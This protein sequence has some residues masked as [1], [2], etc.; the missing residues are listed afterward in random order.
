MEKINI[1]ELIEKN[2]ITKLNDDYNM[3]LLNKIRETFTDFEQQL[4]VSSFYCY[5]NYNS[6]TDFVIDLDDVWKFM[7]FNQKYNALRVLEKNFKVE[8][9]YKQLYPQGK[10]NLIIKPE[11]QNNI[12]KLF[13]QP[14]EIKKGSGGYNIK[15]IFLTVKCFKSMCLK[16]GTKKAD[17]IHEY[18]MKL[19]EILHE[20][21]DEQCTEL[22]NQLNNQI[23]INE[24]II[25]EHEVKIAE[26]EQ[27]IADKEN[28]K[29]K[30]IEE[31]ELLNLNN[32]FPYIYIF[33]KDT[34]R[35]IP[36]L[37]I[38][39]S[40]NVY[41]R[42]K[43]FKCTNP[44]SKL[45]YYIKIDNKPILIVENFIHNLLQKYN[46]GGEVFELPVEKAIIIIKSIVTFMNIV[47]EDENND[48]LHRLHDSIQ[49]I[50]SNIPDP[51][52]FTN[53]IST[54]T[55]FIPE[56]PLS[57][58]IIQNDEL[59]L[60]FNQYIDECCIVRDD[61]EV[62]SSEIIGQYRIWSKTAGEE[63]FHSFKEYLDTRFRPKR[64]SHQIKDQI[65]HGYSGVKLKEILYKRLLV[66]SN[67]QEFIFNCCVFKPDGKVLYSELLKEYNRWKKSIHKP[68]LETD[69]KTLK[70]YLKNCEY[71]LYRNVW[72]SQG[73]GNGFYGII[74]KNN[75]NE[76]F[77]KGTSSTG[78]RVEKRSYIN[79]ELLGTWET[80]AKAASFEKCS[81]A[82]MSRSIKNK[83]V[84]NNDY[85]YC[86]I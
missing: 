48:K 79:E 82:K 77:H 66:D 8:F 12:E 72:T 78:K 51:K 65:V 11:D 83:V 50:D 16:A 10:N 52:I 27:I 47:D 69:E 23:K 29:L 15:K 36:Q 2:P 13:M 80:I 14:P 25:I 62:G 37:K 54:Q 22:K 84:F 74:L 19:E 41:N 57:R 42:I 71:T 33:N 68:V 7:G 76:Y 59:K 70:S 45:E 18:Y 44:I 40:R 26:R 35:D 5:L 64:L 1:A 81:A 30:L 39:Y 32:N 46:I 31:K 73:N 9:D 21:I 56:E 38:G 17:E 43:G 4:F 60:K 6:N 63:I 28:E 49:V 75:E 55:E 34:R 24:N 85:Y 3:L 58:P 86:S 53:T 61:V 20:I 67:E